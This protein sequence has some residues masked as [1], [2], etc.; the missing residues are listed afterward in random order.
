M[1]A[2]RHPAPESPL[3]VRLQAKHFAA[4]D[5]GDWDVAVS[6]LL[7]IQ[8]L[9]NAIRTLPSDIKKEQTP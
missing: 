4:L 8:E 2:T 1:S 7:S 9:R 5:E 6:T 3:I